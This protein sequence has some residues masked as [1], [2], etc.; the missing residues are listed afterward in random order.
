MKWIH[1]ENDVLLKEGK[2][3]EIWIYTKVNLFIE[4]VVYS[5]FNVTFQII[6]RNC[7]FEITEI[8][9]L[10]PKDEKV[11]ICTYRRWSTGGHMMV[12]SRHF[13]VGCSEDT[14]VNKYWKRDASNKK[15]HA[16]S[17]KEKA[18]RLSNLL[19][20]ATTKRKVW[21]PKGKKGYMGQTTWCDWLWQVVATTFW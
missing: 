13:A 8:S 10:I 12:S 5:Y 4:S 11:I 18:C 6:L 2:S 14:C 21:S 7:I 19:C 16:K 9:A 1:S 17:N 20:Y 15:R 3:H